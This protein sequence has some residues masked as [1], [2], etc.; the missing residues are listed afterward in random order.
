[1]KSLENNMDIWNIIEEHSQTL[2]I[3]EEKT[4]KLMQH[5]SEMNSNDVHENKA[6]VY[7]VKDTKEG[8]NLSDLESCVDSLTEKVNNFVKNVMIVRS[9]PQK[10]MEMQKK[11]NRLEQNIKG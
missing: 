7:E 9:L 8:Q 2:N 1:M 5:V 6:G 3:M 11:L 10:V 4:I